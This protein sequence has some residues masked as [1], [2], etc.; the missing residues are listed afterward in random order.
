MARKHRPA[1]PDTG[2]KTHRRAAG[3]WQFRKFFWISLLRFPSVVCPHTQ[4]AGTPTAKENPMQA[5]RFRLGPLLVCS[6]LGLAHAAPPALLPDPII[7]TAT[8]TPQKVADLL[9]DVRVIDAEDIAEAGTQTLTELLQAKGGVE[10]S[11]NGGPGQVSGVFIRGTNTNHVVV[12]I[13][14][15]RINSATTGTNALENIPLEQIERIEI[16]RGP[17]SSLYGADAIGGVIQVFTRKGGDAFAANGGAGYGSYATS[18]V[19]GGV[20]GSG[21]DGAWRYALQVG[22]RQSDGF[23]AIFNARNFSYNPDRDGYRNDN[24]SGSLAFRFAP[25]QEISAQACCSRLN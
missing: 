6:P 25:E 10:I 17:A 23:N 22:H 7:V 9:A 14:G 21:A 1:S 8:R 20:S 3:S 16:L 15:V 12:L 11:A 4:P 18:S 2:L 24:V 19:F 5:F 13:D